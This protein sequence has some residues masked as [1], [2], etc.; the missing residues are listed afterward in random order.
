MNQVI[1]SA[2]YIR[3]NANSRGK[4]VDDCVKRALS[5]AFN[6][7][8]Q[9]ISK[10][11]NTLCKELGLSTDEYSR[12][13]IFTKLVERY[14]CKPFQD[15]RNSNLTLS[16]FADTIGSSGTFLV[17]TGRTS[18]R[19]NHIVCCIDG[20]IYDSWDSLSQYAIYYTQVPETFNHNFTNISDSIDDLA[21]LSEDLVASYADKYLNKF[22]IPNDKETGCFKQQT[23]KV[24]GYTIKIDCYYTYTE[25]DELIYSKRFTLAFVLTPTMSVDQAKTYI[26]NT[27]RTRIYDRCYEMHK[28]LSDA[29]EGSNLFNLSGYDKPYRAF[30]GRGRSY[31]KSLPGWVK[32]FLL[33]ADVGNDRTYEYNYLIY[34]RPLPGDSDTNIVCLHGC[35]SNDIKEELARYKVDYSRVDI[36]YLLDEI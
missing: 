36:D 18:N 4:N 6:T 16:E 22:E 23:S 24:D 11:L 1:Y 29:I 33:T 15:I 27:A 7:S 20:T 25:S 12:V 17:R 32:P 21:D 3:Y 30:I 14:G 10:Q 9:N 19:D 26:S 31:A 28:Q 35:T 5:L 2:D 34:F 13:S 8:Y